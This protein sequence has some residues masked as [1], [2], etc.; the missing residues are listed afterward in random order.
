M[1]RRP[2]GRSSVKLREVHREILETNVLGHADRRDAV[3]GSVADLP[4]VLVPDLDSVGETRLLD[5]PTRLNNLLFADGDSHNINVEK[6]GGMDR[7]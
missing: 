1:R 4:I 2:P 7:H 3:V 6:A 5:P